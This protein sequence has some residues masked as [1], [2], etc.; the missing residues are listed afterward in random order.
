[1]KATQA[2]YG[3]LDTRKFELIRED[4]AS[5][6]DRENVQRFCIIVEWL[7][8]L[9]LSGLQI[10]NLATKEV[11]LLQYRA[12][13]NTSASSIIYDQVEL[14]RLPDIF[15]RRIEVIQWSDGRYRETA[16]ASVVLWY[17]FSKN[18]SK[19]L[20]KLDFEIQPNCVD[21]TERMRLMG[22]L[23]VSDWIFPCKKWNEPLWYDSSLFHP[24]VFSEALSIALTYVLKE[25]E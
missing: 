5:A 12:E 17:R 16:R 24:H 1:M 25:E 10:M 7:V 14:D 8:A 20:E 11:V 23:W 22:K 13:V 9:K 4:I 2:W 18:L 19:F 15:K 21:N 6:Q 3:V